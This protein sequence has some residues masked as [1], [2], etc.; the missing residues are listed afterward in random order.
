MRIPFLEARAREWRE[1]EGERALE[2]PVRAR[3]CVRFG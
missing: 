1:G 2:D 3:V